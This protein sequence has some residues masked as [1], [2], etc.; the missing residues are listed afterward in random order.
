MSDQDQ[1]DGS[2]LRAF[3]AETLRAVMAGISDVGSDA[4]VRSIHG[5]GEYN[6]KAPERIDFDVAVSAEHSGT[7]RGG[8]KLQVFGVGANAGGDVTSKGSTVSR[9]VFSV[10]TDF[11]RYN[12]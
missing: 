10:P 2:E 12:L 4:S 3:V 7:A 9:I 1:A 8:F 5:H 11:K 6:F